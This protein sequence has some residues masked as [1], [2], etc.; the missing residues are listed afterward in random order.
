MSFK[1]LIAGAVSGF[2]SAF[3]VDLNAWKKSPGV[4][5]NWSLAIQ[6]WILG[7]VTGAYGGSGAGWL[8]GEG[9]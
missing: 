8:M 3:L 1:S 9:G 2:L 6:R 7:A 4:A 5:F